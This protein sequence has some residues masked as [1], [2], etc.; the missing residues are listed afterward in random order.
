MTFF[1]PKF[2]ACK[3]CGVHFDPIPIP[4]EHELGF[5]YLCPTHRQTAINSHLRVLKIVKWT[6]ANLDKVER[7]MQEDEAKRSE[8]AWGGLSPQQ[9]A[10]MCLQ[11]QAMTD[12]AI[13][14]QQDHQHQAT[15]RA[16]QSMTG[17]SIGNLGAM[18]P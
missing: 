8:R 9:A 15:D 12:A 11:K 14:A 16:M 13:Q 7:L 10:A 18:K 3:T 2:T 6:K 1:K 5:G 4:I 17:A